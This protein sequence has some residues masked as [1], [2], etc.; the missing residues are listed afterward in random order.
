MLTKNNK[1]SEKFNDTEQV[2]E[3][4]GIGLVGIIIVVVVG[5]IVLA[6]IFFAS[7]GT[8]RTTYILQDYN[9]YD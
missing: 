6:I 1:L 8:R 7:S 2:E 3:E 5:V 9:D 4:E